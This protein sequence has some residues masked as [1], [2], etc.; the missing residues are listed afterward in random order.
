MEESTIYILKIIDWVCFCLGMVSVF[1]LLAF[2]FASLFNVLKKYPETSGFKKFL[3]IFPAYKEDST[4][5][6]S[7]KEFLGQKYP[8]CYFDVAVVSDHM[9][10]ETNASLSELPIKLLTAGYEDSSKAKALQF[11][12]EGT[13]GG[14]YDMVVIMD[15]DNTADED[16]LADMNNT[17]IFESA[18]QAHRTAKNRNT[19]TAVLDALSEEINNSIFRK[20]HINLGLSSALTGSGMAFD[21]EWFCANVDK[22]ATSGEDKEL[23]I[24]LLK[25]KVHITYLENT[26]VYD[27]KTQKSSGFYNQRRRWIATQFYSLKRSFL[28]FIPA[29]FRG[30]ADYLD[31]IFQWMLPPRILHVGIIGI[32]ALVLTFISVS[33]SIKWWILLGVLIFAL[34]MA[35]P[36]H[37]WDKKLL[38][39]LI[40]IPVIFVLM[41][42]NLFR[43]KGADKKFIHTEKS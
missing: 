36:E 14:E 22:L 6:P 34:C 31:K 3:V 21:Y 11:A 9:K 28:D 38:K 30:N 29:L 25:Q 24:L 2:S 12:I 37:Y 8:R 41:A 10:D 42:A 27:H 15:A 33:A 5:I 35:I 13:R 17:C 26:Y 20:G 43:V 16:F 7:V 19:N 40:N 32:I 4:I 18:I 1:Y 23:E 39:A